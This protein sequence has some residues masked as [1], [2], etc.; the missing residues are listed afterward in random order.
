MAFAAV[1]DAREDAENRLGKL[2]EA[3]RLRREREKA[4]AQEA[5]INAQEADAPAKPRA[6][7]KPRR[8]R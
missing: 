3:M 8:A 1:I 7:G 5:A 6:S 2:R 4:A